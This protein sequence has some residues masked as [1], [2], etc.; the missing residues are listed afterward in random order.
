MWTYDYFSQILI[1]IREV[2][3]IMLKSGSE[4][5]DLLPYVN[6]IYALR[7]L[8]FESLVKYGNFSRRVMSLRLLEYIFIEHYLADDSKGIFVLNPV[9]F[10]W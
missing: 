2:G 3:Q 4:D 8:S 5:S 6:F 7:E 10:F 9:F 1:R